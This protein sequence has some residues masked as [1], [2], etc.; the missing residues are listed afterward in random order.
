[1]G[2]TPAEGDLLLGRY[3]LGPLVGLGGTAKVFRAWDQE[4]GGTVAVKVF[5]PGSASPTRDGRREREV[6][7]GVRHAGL[8]E[9]RDSGVDDEGFPFVVMDFIEGE[10][11]AARLRRGPVPPTVVAELGSTLAA[12]MA[13]VHERGIVHRDIKP[14]NVLLD[15]DGRPWLAD[16]GIARIVDAT[17][18]TA[19]GVVVGTAAYMAP[20]QVRGEAVGPAADVYALGLV[21]LEAV[22][23]RREY[24]GGAL[25]SALAR[26]NRSPRVP[27]DVPDPLAAT[28]RRMT[29]GEP[30]ERPS[31]EQVAAALAEP[32][33][34]R[35]DPPPRHVGRRLV[36]VG[37]LVVLA[38]TALGGALLLG[39]GGTG[40]AGSQAGAAAGPDFGSAPSGVPAAPQAAAP[41][42]PVAPAPVVI[43]PVAAAA[44]VA[45]VPA[46]VAPAP[47]ARAV[48]AAPRPAAPSD[49]ASPP[50]AATTQ[51][52]PG[53][54]AS[55]AADPPAQDDQ[56]DQAV[57]K[58]ENENKGKGNNNNK[59]NGQN[60]GNGSGNKG[61]GNNGSGNNGSGN[62]QG[63]D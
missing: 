6:L 53:Q 34:Y 18:V 33:P 39:A 38:T 13:H 57:A 21:L 52:A 2:A 22:T 16:F 5:P 12:A 3:T 51:S 10:S 17:R 56:G 59:H 44:R 55:T 1:M 36:P 7:T 29:L 46:G 47:A 62:D 61:N 8:I 25:E 60:N 27:S 35:I 50:R 4:G 20:E 28:I 54:T 40:G 41:P 11:L 30:A 49:A 45:A 43:A 14:G 23:G 9:I 15:E 31:A 42:A 48:V 58:G 19:T 37:A 32:P 63:E 26:L 24:D